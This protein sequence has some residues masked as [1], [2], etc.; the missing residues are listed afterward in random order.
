MLVF[1]HKGMSQRDAAMKLWEISDAFWERVEPLIPQQMRD[2]ERVYRRTAGGGRKPLE[3]RKVF[4]AIVYVL[5]TGIQWK[6]LPKELYGSPSSIHAYFKKWEAQGFFEEL[7]KRGLAEFEEMKGI[8]WEW[9]I[10]KA[11]AREFAAAMQAR[12]AADAAKAR[13]L[14]SRASDAAAAAAASMHAK[15][16]ELSESIKAQIASARG[17]DGASGKDDSTSESM[18]S[19]DFMKEFRVWRPVVARRSRE[20]AKALCDKASAL[21]T[22]K[23]KS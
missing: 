7:W 16:T 19:F 11:K 6:S 8:H 9:T 23:F 20:Q 1:F 22:D 15:A 18:E 21:F 5:R 17:E 2:P 10:D 13:E 4:S 3:P 12:A 14:A